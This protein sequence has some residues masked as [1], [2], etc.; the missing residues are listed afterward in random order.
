VPIT[1]IAY[2][3]PLVVVVVETVSPEAP[4]PPKTGLVANSHAGGET[5][6]DG[7]ETAQDRLT[8]PV[9]LFTEAIVTVEVAMNP[10]IPDAGLNA[11]ALTV[12]V[13]CEYLATKA[14]IFGVNVP[15]FSC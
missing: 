12:N 11:E 8:L 14:L 9:K 1:V 3:P 7:P 10:G 13:G 5:A 4:A 2:T 6:F 15:L